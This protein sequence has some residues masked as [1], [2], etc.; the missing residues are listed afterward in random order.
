MPVVSGYYDTVTTQTGGYLAADGTIVLADASNG[1]F[2]VTLP[3]PSSG[4]L[5]E[6]KKI[7]GTN[8]QVTIAT[9]GSETIDGQS[10]IVL[11]RQYVVREITSDGSNYFIV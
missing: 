7:D 8:N 2:D 4:D 10:E 9:P 6:V 11:E 5:V 1:P 3:S